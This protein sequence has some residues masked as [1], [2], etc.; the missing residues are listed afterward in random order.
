MVKLYACILIVFIRSF[1]CAFAE[2]G[3]EDYLLGVEFFSGLKNKRDFPAALNSLQKAASAGH[4]QASMLL[5]LMKFRGLGE[6]ADPINGLAW[7]Y[8]S[9]K[10]GAKG[11]G[12]LVISLEK[13]LDPGSIEQAKNHSLK[14][15]SS[16]AQGSKSTPA[17][18]KETKPDQMKALL[19][20]AD[21]GDAGAMFEV[22]RI[23]AE[24]K[25]IEKDE[26]KSKT[27]LEKAAYA[28][29]AEAKTL[30]AKR[31]ADDGLASARSM[32]NQEAIKIFQKGLDL[33][34][35][36]YPLLLGL[37]YA[38]NSLGLDFKTAKKG[39]DAEKAFRA[40][41][42]TSTRLTEKHPGKA[43]GFL[44]LAMSTGNLAKFKGGREKIKI[45][46]KVEEYCKTAIK[47]DPSLGMA[48]AVLGT[49]YLAVV[50]L[51]WLLKAFAKSFLG[52]LP[53]ATEEDVLK[54]YEDG[55]KASP[56]RIYTLLKYGQMLQRLDKKE[57]A[58]E[59]F[60]TLL[61]LTPRRSEESRDQDYA[62][63]LLKELGG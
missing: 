18:Q 28:G 30:L 39:E 46:S 38:Q 43:E 4:G 14:L 13:A 35:N 45:G 37:S 56:D 5:G 6:N 57:E 47:L 52:K 58:K 40:A 51:P 55:A 54:L 8:V 1:G 29:H 12:E 3:H 21:G 19:S 36:S 7:T 50:D 41:I 42:E 15:L 25:E 63:T 32:N 10:R 34:S 20:R 16:T 48:H 24:G 62:R 11:S 26:G 31:F 17:P 2:P 27:Y 23:L 60:N 59:K 9:A 61:K 22:S 49:Y 33:S 44:I 53:D